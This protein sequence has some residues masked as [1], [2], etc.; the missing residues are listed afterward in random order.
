[1]AILGSSGCAETIS[2]LPID[3]RPEPLTVLRQGP[4]ID[5]ALVRIEVPAP[6][7]FSNT[8]I[9]PQVLK[10]AIETAIGASFGRDLSN[11]VQITAQVVSSHHPAFSQSFRTTLSVRY[12]VSDSG[13][14][15]LFDETIA[16]EG[17]DDTGAFL[18]ATRSMR[19]MSL[20]ISNNAAAFRDRLR[21]ALTAEI[22]AGR[23]AGRSAARVEQGP[24]P[25]P[26]VAASTPGAGRLPTQ[27]IDLT[28]KKAPE[29][30]DDIAVI[31]A[32]ADYGRLARD[33][34]NVVPAYADAE[35]FRR[36]AIQTLGVREGNIILLKDATGA[37]ITRVFGSDT[38]PR[39]QL[40]DWIRPSR[41][42]V[43]VYYAGH[44]APGGVGGS[45]Y[46][47]PVDADAARIELN[48]YPLETLY[49][50]LARLPAVSVTVV[51]EACFSGNSQA[52]RVQPAA[53]DIVPAAKPVPIPPNITVISA[54]ASN[55]IASWEED[56]AHGLFTK[57][58]L[59]AM[60]GEADR[61][62]YGNGDGTVDWQ[63]ARAYLTETVT[64]HA[65]RY[66]GRDQ[67]PEISVGK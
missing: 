65:R 14:Q 56:R 15:R 58:F 64:Y 18:G 39:G 29:R 45:A 10:S 33:I 42:R 36:Y 4:L 57:Y 5:S 67:T 13:G 66:Y 30:P 9:A 19:A 43:H 25:P 50:N 49:R 2:N 41:S 31:I 44:G 54:G 21:S 51:L 61:P 24:G 3:V 59:K 46:L 35:G 22:A 60:S 7:I 28:F 53:S 26:P 8:E 11:P 55:Q 12:T 37:Q 63:E 40:A 52:G 38:N 16:S 48:G 32:N 20:T 62:P 23:L 27:P 34:P 17:A 6:I 47:V 1:M